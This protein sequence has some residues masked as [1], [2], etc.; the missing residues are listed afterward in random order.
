LHST[1]FTASST[2]PGSSSSGRPGGAFVDPRTSSTLDRL[3]QYRPLLPLT[4]SINYGLTG[5]HS[6]LPR[7]QPARADRREPAGLRALPRADSSLSRAS[8]SRAQQLIIAG[9]T[10][11]LLPCSS[12]RIAVNYISAR[13]LLLMQCFFL[14]ALLAYARTRRLGGSPLRWTTVLLLLALS[15]LA[16]TNLVVAPL[17]VLA[18]DVIVAR[19]SLRSRGVW[20]RVLAATAVVAGFFVLTRIVLGFS[21][22]EQVVSEAELGFVC[23]H[24]G[25]LHLFHYLP[26]FW[27]PFS[28]R[29][30]PLIGPVR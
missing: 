22:L 23:R 13:D 27:W 10:A 30:L 25:G 3:A 11:L 17:L 24:T 9:F 6:R 12:Q 19:D 7:G 1:T 14:A 2:T 5:Q 18:F 20:L 15:L 21:D 28:I 8:L 4:L 16:K 29:Q 26:H